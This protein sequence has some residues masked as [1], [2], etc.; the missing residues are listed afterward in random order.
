[1]RIRDAIGS[2]LV[3]VALGA[4]LASF[5]GRVRGRL[6]GLS[7]RVATASWSVPSHSVATDNIYLAGFLVAGAVLV[8]LML[9]T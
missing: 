7:G 2:V 4:V 1:M 5:D 3:V 9:K 8:G 6:E